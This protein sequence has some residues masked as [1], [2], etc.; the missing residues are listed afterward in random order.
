MARGVH[1]L[2]RM[3]AGRLYEGQSRDRDRERVREWDRRGTT[4]KIK[5]GGRTHTI[6]AFDGGR[7][8]LT[9][10]SLEKKL[11]DIFAAP[12]IL[13]RDSRLWLLLLV[14]IVHGAETIVRVHLLVLSLCMFRLDLPD[15]LLLQRKSAP[16][17][18]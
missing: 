12:F 7:K 6:E 15:T 14:L 4:R 5:W 1:V 9:L 2:G 8:L 3:G 13:C 10:H 16:T 18:A 11:S 17:I